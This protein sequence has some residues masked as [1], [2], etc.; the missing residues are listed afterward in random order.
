MHYKLNVTLTEADYYNFNYFQAF[1]TPHGKKTLLKCRII[2]ALCMALIAAI[3][4]V[5]RGWSQTSMIYVLICVLLTVVFSLFLKKIMVNSLKKQ[6]IE[7]K[8]AGKL[9]FSPKSEIEFCENGIVETTLTERS[10]KSY[11][12]IEKICV[13]GDRYI[14]LYTSSIGAYILPLSQV[15]TQTGKK[16]LLDFLQTKCNKIECYK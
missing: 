11:D 9:H 2:L 13:L 5:I 6:L 4:V 16:K 8:K 3:A 1:E 12:A 10:E 7:L 14:F 15:K